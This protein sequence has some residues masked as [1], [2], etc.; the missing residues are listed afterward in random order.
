MSRSLVSQDARHRTLD[1]FDLL[2]DLLPVAWS[3]L[4]V[5]IVIMSLIM[6]IAVMNCR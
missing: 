2:E 6:I 3:M 4:S 1:D 5:V